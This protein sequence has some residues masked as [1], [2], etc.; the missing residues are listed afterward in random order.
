[1]ISLIDWPQQAT[2][3]DYEKATEK[4]CSVVLR[5]CPELSIYT[6][7]HLSNPG[8][9][10]ID[11]LF[12]FP[13]EYEYKE[14]PLLRLDGKA[15]YLFTHS[16]FGVSQSDFES[17]IAGSMFHNVAHLSGLEYRFVNQQKALPECI[18]EQIALEYLVKASGILFTQ[19]SYGILK[20]RN[21]LLELK[22]LAF[23]LEILGVKGELFAQIEQIIHWRNTWFRQTPSKTEFVS[24]IKQFDEHLRQFL[25]AY[26]RTKSIFAEAEEIRMSSFTLRKSDGFGRQIQKSVL[27]GFPAVLLGRKYFNLLH[28]FNKVSLQLPVC[29]EYTA[30]FKPHANLAQELKQYNRNY[31]PFFGALNHF[32]IN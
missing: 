3:S 2:V 19:L 9:S 25:I 29:T 10:D 22:A 16:P 18:R 8:I 30:E 1:M 27:P 17:A 26:F 6:L 28:R 15:A 31:L 24:L 4:M 14:N 12:V 20:V 7:G 5:A 11:M 21:L 23:D 13:N 32:I